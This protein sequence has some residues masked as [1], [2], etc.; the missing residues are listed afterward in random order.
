MNTNQ[1]LVTI[2]KILIN[3]STLWLSNRDIMFVSLDN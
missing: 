3:V 2:V 1:F